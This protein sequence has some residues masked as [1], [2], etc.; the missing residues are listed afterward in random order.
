MNT[1]PGILIRTRLQRPKLPVGYWRHALLQQRLQGILSHRLTLLLAPAGFG[2]SLALADWLERQ[3]RSDAALPDEA[4]PG[5]AP[6]AGPLPGE[7]RLRDRSVPPADGVPAG[8]RVQ[9]AWV[10]LE[11]GESDA[12]SLAAYVQ[13][14]LAPLP[15]G[16]RR[17]RLGRTLLTSPA[18]D[19]DARQSLTLCLAALAER[20]DRRPQAVPLVLVLDDVHWLSDPAAC[21]WLE[22]LMRE[23]PEHVH[24]VLCGRQPPPLSVADLQAR[25]DV[26][27]LGPADLRLPAA[28]LPAFSACVLNQRLPA[29][30]LDYLHALVG[31]WPLAWQ[32][33]LREL[34]A[35]WDARTAQARRPAM[36]G[37]L[38]AFVRQTVLPGLTDRQQEFLLLVAVTPELSP[39]LA[40]ALAGVEDGPE[41]LDALALLGL[42]ERVPGQ[43]GMR[44]RLE[45]LLCQSLRERLQR[46]QP[47]RILLQHRRAATWFAEQGEWEAAISHALEGAEFSAAAGWLEQGAENLLEQGRFGELLD[48]LARL[49][50]ET[51]ESRPRLQ[52]AQAWALAFLHQ[53]EQASQA[54]HGLEQQLQRLQHE[55]MGVRAA[56]LALSDDSPSALE[57]GR[58]VLAQSPTPGSLVDHAAHTAVI[59]GLGSASRFEEVDALRAAEAGILLPGTLSALY[60]QNLFGYSAFLAGRLDQAG[61][62][63]EDALA[64]AT[65]AGMADS[66]AAAVAAAYLAA[67]HYERNDAERAR[68]LLE[69]RRDTVTAGASLGALLHLLRTEARLASLR[70]DLPDALTAL[71]QGER[72]GH[73]RGQRRL[74]AGCLGEAVRLL[75]AHGQTLEADR[76]LRRLLVLGIHAPEERP[77]AASDTAD[78]VRLAEGRM[79]LALNAP[80][81][82]VPVLRSLWDDLRHGR[83]AYMAA[84]VAVS[85]VRALEAAGDPEGALEPL[86][87]ALIYGQQNGLVRTFADEGSVLAGPIARLLLSGVAHPDVDPEYLRRLRLLLDPV[88]ARTVTAGPAPT[89]RLSARETEILQYMARGLSN[90]E[91]A[92]ALGISPETVKWYLK[93][94]YDKLQVSGRVQ[95][96]QAGLG[97]RAAPA[98][99]ADPD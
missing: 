30:T 65:A 92:R 57:A 4:R 99:E 59:F 75:L 9:A 77:T 41:L 10:R 70:G 42:V 26:L 48:W 79:L 33:A 11:A 39:G 60:R 34:R 16:E 76:L 20:D 94:I 52:L 58:Q 78:M 15:V 8:A 51:R 87:Q 54:L 21:V 2:K 29:E 64:R 12:A 19:L 22:R 86:W 46:E 96:V 5:E 66:Q 38:E 17:P 50:G 81:R 23:A 62:I 61:L 35:P 25:G 83:R 56:L 44:F 55:A 49:P 18:A 7:L 67:I 95:A 73:A 24:L 89:P 47:G 32:C 1:H 6:P 45:P 84:S 3:E 28:G 88:Y 97:I 53:R 31:G 13:A 71:E 98:A 72:L 74:Q 69:G 36:L 63:F 85:L 68:S 43:P 14:A 91:I 90:K 93:Q 37:A 80:R 40:E 82:A 27:M